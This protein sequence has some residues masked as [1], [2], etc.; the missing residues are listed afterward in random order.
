MSA[1]QTNWRRDCVALLTLYRTEWVRLSE[2]FAFVE[3]DIPIHIA[4][5]RHVAQKSQ[6]EI[7]VNTARWRLFLTHVNPLVERK[8]ADG[9]AVAFRAKRTDLVRLLPHAVPCTDC[10]G[11]RF[12]VAWPQPGL[13]RK[14]AC[15]N[16][17]KPVAV[18]EPIPEPAIPEPVR[19]TL[20][21][22][23]VVPLAL[24]EVSAPKKLNAYQRRGSQPPP[25]RATLHLPNPPKPPRPKPKP[26]T[27]RPVTLIPPANPKMV[28][29]IPLGLN[30]TARFNNCRTL[31]QNIKWFL[32]FGSINEIER[33]IIT[34]HNVSAVLAKRGS[35]LRDFIARI[36]FNILLSKA[37]ENS[38]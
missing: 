15:P 12:L 31:A 8:S 37:K 21:P 26:V 9:E 2:L 11:P 25:K 27:I 10:G 16:C 22:E 30:Y 20:A 1:N 36:N 29:E 5:R 3:P 19:V 23:P 34:T 17:A 32:G 24:A 35:T 14:Y 33:E 28:I 38:R 4:M 13:P 6:V 7:G 18:P